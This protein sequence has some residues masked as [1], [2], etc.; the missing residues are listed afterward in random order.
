MTVEG[1]QPAKPD[2]HRIA[3]AT[4]PRNVTWMVMRDVLRLVVIGV[5]TGVAALLA[6]TRAVQSQLCELTA[7]DPSTLALATAGLAL[8]ACA[9]GYLPGLRASRL[10]PMVALQ[11]E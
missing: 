2:D 7:P 6:L 4:E 5:G 11:Y 10:D 1:C 3:L 9:A 8:V